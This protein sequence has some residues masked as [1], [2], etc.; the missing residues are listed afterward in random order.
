M[1]AIE[2]I[3]L[4]KKYRHVSRRFLF[5]PLE[6][7]EYEALKGISFSVEG[8]EIVGYLG[9]NGS[10][11][12]TTIKIL[13]GILWPDGG[14]VRVA[15][16][17]PWER[18]EEFL[19]RIGV[20]F[21]QRTSLLWEVPVIDSLEIFREMYGV[22]RK[23]FEERLEEV[24]KYLKIED[25]LEKPA[26]ELSLGERIRCEMASILLHDPDVL[27][28]DEPTI[29]VDIWTRQKIRRLLKK[30]KGEGKA[31]LLTSH[32]LD[33]VEAVADRVILLQRGK[34][35]YD[36]DIEGLRALLPY[37]RITVV[38]S[39]ERE[40]IDEG[41]EQREGNV[42]VLRVERERT[43]EV[44]KKIFEAYDVLDLKVEEPDLE[45]V[46]TYTLSDEG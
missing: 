16:Y 45:E 41:V 4:R 46:L 13:S 21:G 43:A 8:G 29:G 19:K 3:D 44:V 9:P 6:Y 28:L 12:S 10:G 40:E 24:N 23:D 1:S 31:I 32:Q 36:G 34:I 30:L 20:I 5:I 37:K 33:E 25:Y 26:M 27:F 15:G 11:K 18:K 22:E 2:V 39:E 17:I 7:S 38:F 35:I 42:I 14:K